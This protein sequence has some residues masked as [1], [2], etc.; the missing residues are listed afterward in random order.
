MA[1]VQTRWSLDDKKI[2]N[3][4][5]QRIKGAMM[6]LK[7]TL[8]AIECISLITQQEQNHDKF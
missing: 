6:S 2:T 1:I 4:F 7:S 5:S 8:I 3:I